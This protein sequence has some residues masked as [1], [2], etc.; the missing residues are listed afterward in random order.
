MGTRGME[1]DASLLNFGE[2]LPGLLPRLIS[3]T[4]PRQMQE[5]ND[6]APHDR[7]GLLGP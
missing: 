6:Q 1:H 2:A 7:C 4:A 5:L 3:P